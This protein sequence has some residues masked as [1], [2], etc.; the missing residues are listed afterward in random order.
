MLLT[1]RMWVY[2][3]FPRTYR[4]I[5]RA[6]LAARNGRERRLAVAMQQRTF[7]SPEALLEAHFD[8]WVDDY[9]NTRPGFLLAL[10]LLGG[11]PARIVE[12]GTSAWGTDST[13]LFDAYVRVFGGEFWSIDIRKEPG[14]RLR[15][16]MSD[17]TRL[18]VGDSVEVINQLALQ[19][20]GPI[21]LFYLDSYDLD[22]NN[23][24]P[25]ASHGLAEWNALQPLTA[26]GTL[27]LVDDTPESPEW[28][29]DMKQGWHDSS[30]RWLVQNGY[31]PGKGAFIDR[32]VQSGGTVVK[33]WHGYNVLYQFQ[34]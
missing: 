13:R 1:G 11:R 32:S 8:A 16:T 22:W 7:E 29:P 28:V 30:Q 6:R 12:T 15:G 23:P 19:D 21:D 26:V 27:V 31:V 14:D 3:R 34:S 20:V 25:A 17:R 5:H 9:Q 33:L 18:L 10:Q 4:S 2:T 24:V